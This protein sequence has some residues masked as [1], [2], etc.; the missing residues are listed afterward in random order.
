[1]DTVAELKALLKKHE[2]DGWTKMLTD[3]IAEAKDIAIR[4]GLQG[5]K[6]F[7]DGLEGKNGY[8]AYLE[9]MVR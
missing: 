5:A 1:M 4:R 8:Y 7:P 2:A 9:K 6:D 3:S